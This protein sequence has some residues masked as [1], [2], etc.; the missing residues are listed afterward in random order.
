MLAA[1]FGD[2]HANFL[3]EGYDPRTA[4]GHGGGGLGAF[5]RNGVNAL[6]LVA[7]LL[8]FALLLMGGIRYLTAGGDAKA[9]EAAMKMITNA[10]IG[11]AIVIAAY[12][13][14]TILAG[15]FGVDIFKPNFVGP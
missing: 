10:V 6:F 15:L 12:G 13:L 8:T 1:P 3:V 4:A 7:G 11:L 14:A 2:I 9:T 5:I